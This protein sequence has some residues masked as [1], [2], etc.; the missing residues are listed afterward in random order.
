MTEN[1]IDS[2]DESIEEINE[3][4]ITKPIKKINNI[5]SI[6]TIYNTY[7]N[8]NN[9]NLK[10]NYQREL[11]WSFD[12]MCIFID[13]IMKGYVIPSFILSV[14]HKKNNNNYNYECIDGQHRLTVLQK[15]MNSEFIKIGMV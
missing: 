7:F 5:T 6:I 10:P 14:I 3:I 13:S 12:K 9:I 2:D 1:Y 4:E 8:R 11:I 15:Y